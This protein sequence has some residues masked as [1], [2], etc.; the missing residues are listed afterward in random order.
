[1][2]AAFCGDRLTASS[3]ACHLTAVLALARP[4]V[5]LNGSI[6]GR[7]WSGTF[8][9]ALSR[10]ARHAFNAKLEPLSNDGGIA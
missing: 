7:P 4:K 10:A 8:G 9:V 1:M 3:N 5:K 2:L 6:V